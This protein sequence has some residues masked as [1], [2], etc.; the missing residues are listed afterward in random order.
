V[1]EVKRLVRCEHDTIAQLIVH[2]AEMDGRDIH[3]AA[4]YPSLYVYCLEELHLSGYEAYNRIEVA[5]AGKAFP[6]IFR[7]LEDGSLTLTTVQ[8]LARRLTAE[9]EDELLSAAAGRSK[10]QVQELLARHFPRPDAPPT[11]RK[12]S[13]PRA[14]FALSGGDAPPV[15]VDGGASRNPAPAPVAPTTPASPLK[16]RPVA[17]L[18]PDRYRVT[19]TA[20]AETCKMLDQAK[21]MLRHTVPNGDTAEVMKRALKT[22]LDELAR[23]KCATTEAPRGSRGT[24]T[25]SRYIPASVKRAVWKRDGGRCAFVARSGRRCEERGFVEFHHVESYAKGGKP[26]PENIQLRCRAHNAYE[27]DLEFG[28]RTATRSGPSSSPW[29]GR[30]ASQEVTAGQSFATGIS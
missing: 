7:L 12:L 30:G 4:G 25:R 6:R 26:T 13:Q 20:D 17:P 2:L 1:A 27:A 11:L 19:F 18:A 15:V 16:D 24:A 29:L 21:D 14:M 23:K 5:R 3:L 22:L 10:R 9:N 28:P 8:L